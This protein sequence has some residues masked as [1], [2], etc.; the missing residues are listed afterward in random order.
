[1]NEDD[2]LAIRAVLRRIL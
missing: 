2:S 1:M